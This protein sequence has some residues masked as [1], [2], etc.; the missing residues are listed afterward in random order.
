MVMSMN[1]LVMNHFS[2]RRVCLKDA[3]LFY[4]G[5]TACGFTKTDFA[6]VFKGMYYLNTLTVCNSPMLLY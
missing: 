5:D 6:K 2:Y 1:K 3:I 4:G